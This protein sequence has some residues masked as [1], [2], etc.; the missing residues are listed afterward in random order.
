MAKSAAEFQHRH[1]QEE[2][3]LCSSSGFYFIIDAALENWSGLLVDLEAQT[4]KFCTA[5]ASFA[6]VSLNDG[7]GFVNIKEHVR[8]IRT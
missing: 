8:G 7:E 3:L 1:G 2:H 5:F 6:M 4:D